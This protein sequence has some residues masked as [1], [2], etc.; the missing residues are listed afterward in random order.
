MTHRLNS[1]QQHPSRFK[2][3]GY[4]PRHADPTSAPAKTTKIAP[5]VTKMG[6]AAAVAAAAVLALAGCSTNTDTPVEPQ[7]KTQ[8]I[9]LEDGSEVTCILFDEFDS[10]SESS[11]DTNKFQLQAVDCDWA[12]RRAGVNAKPDTQTLPR[13]VPTITL[14]PEPNEGA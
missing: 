5:A 4:Q 1:A 11:F 9:K 8:D 10:T 3:H 7:T 6:A 14:T 12:H 2:S 13:E